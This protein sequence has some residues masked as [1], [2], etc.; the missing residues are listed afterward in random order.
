MAGGFNPSEKYESQLGW[1]NSQSMKSHKN[2]VPNHQPDI[3]IWGVPKIGVPLI[4]SKSTTIFLKPCCPCDS[5]APSGKRSRTWCWSGSRIR[6]VEKRLV[7]H[8]K[9]EWKSG[10]NVDLR[11][12]IW[13]K[14]GLN[15]ELRWEIWWKSGFNVD[16]RW[17]KNHETQQKAWET[18][19]FNMLAFS[20][21]AWK[22]NPDGFSSTLVVVSYLGLVYRNRVPTIFEASKPP[23]I[24]FLNSR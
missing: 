16:L 12:E 3:Y 9:N 4:S 14:S 15:V 19:W 6:W 5:H 20:N 18:P 11:W 23:T 22:I 17:F 1:W 10:F 7:K 8:G 13:W 21:E 2:H 24:F